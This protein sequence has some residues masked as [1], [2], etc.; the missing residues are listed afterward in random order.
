MTSP[1]LH[2]PLEVINSYVENTPFEW[3]EYIQPEGMNVGQSFDASDGWINCNQN[4]KKYD[5][6]RNQQYSYY[7]NDRACF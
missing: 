1:L 3:I 4:D 2:N 6:S 7:C 5:K